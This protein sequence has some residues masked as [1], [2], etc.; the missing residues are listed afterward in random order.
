M[1][2]I[3]IVFMIVSL[4]I[5]SS[6]TYICYQALSLDPNKQASRVIG[7]KA[8]DFSVDLL[9]GGD[10]IPN[11][12]QKEKISLDDFKGHPVIVNFWASWCE[13]CQ[14]EAHFFEEFWEKY[15]GTGIK[16]LSIA[17]QDDKDSVIA[18]AGALHKTY[19]VGFDTDG[20]ATVDYGITGVPETFFID[21]NGVVQHR[22]VGPVDMALLEQHALTL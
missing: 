16:I 22:E 5:L 2:K 19:M 12:K 21:K 1:K 11:R 6:I 14:G 10:E 15:K 4:T 17:I 3:S 7:K 8:F 13:T 20:K 18:Y 9:Q